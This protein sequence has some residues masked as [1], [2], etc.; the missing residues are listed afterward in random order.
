MDLKNYFDYFLLT[1]G[2]GIDASIIH[3]TSKML[4]AQLDRV[5]FDVAAVK[6][7]PELH[8][9]PQEN[10]LAFRKGAVTP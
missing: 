7:L 10:L 8:P 3:A 4:K 5:A 2:L 1:A 6:A 9:F